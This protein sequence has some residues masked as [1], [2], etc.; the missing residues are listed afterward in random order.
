MKTSNFNTLTELKLEVTK[1]CPMNCLHCS[2]SSNSSC[3][4]SMTIHFAKRI[5][6]E[7]WAMG[8]REIIFT[9]GEP[10]CWPYLNEVVEFSSNIG[11]DVSLY[12]TGLV[13]GDNGVLKV[14]ID[15]LK[16]ALERKIKFIFCIHSFKQE[17]HDFLTSKR[18]SFYGTVKAIEFLKKLDAAVYLHYVPMKLNINQFIQIAF[19][20]KR[21][22]MNGLSILRL[23]PQGRGAENYKKLLPTS[24]QMINFI[25]D[26]MFLKRSNLKDLIKMGSPFNLINPTGYT[27]CPAASKSLSVSASGNCY[28]C[29]GFKFLAKKDYNNSLLHQS[30]EEVYQKSDILN[31]IR[32]IKRMSM[33]DDGV[34]N[35]SC[36]AQKCL[37]NGTLNFK[38][39]DPLLP[40][41]KRFF[42]SQSGV[43]NEAI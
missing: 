28:P 32:E 26:Y 7:F 11:L 41:S 13:L 8:G 4:S 15:I 9:G 43:K 23:V 35:S 40:I 24:N 20:G 17:T 5:I 3:K 10:L 42:S 31:R 34:R 38:S 22:N 21:M 29:D 30:L 14:G 37:I 27:P 16:K 1:Y 36:I 19:F 39:I 6:N 12:T 2:S 25:R 33:K 18:G